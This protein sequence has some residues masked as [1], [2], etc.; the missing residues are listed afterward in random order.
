MCSR[1]SL[2][3]RGRALA[4]TTGLAYVG[5]LG[6]PPLMGALIQGFGWPMM[7][8]SLCVFAVAASFLAARIPAANKP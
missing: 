1:L 6:S 5:F 4:L 3:Q 7:W 8:L 2:S